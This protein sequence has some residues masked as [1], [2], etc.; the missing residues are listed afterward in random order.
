MCCVCAGSC[1]HIGNHS[2]CYA[3]ASNQRPIYGGTYKVD[4]SQE[5]IEMLR[6]ITEALE[7]IDGRIQQMNDAKPVIS[8]QI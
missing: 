6:R 1:N 8:V 2:F 4:R 7:R 5:I 3:H